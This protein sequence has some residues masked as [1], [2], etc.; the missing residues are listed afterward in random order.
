MASIARMKTQK[1]TQAIV[2]V[3]S[4]CICAAKIS[5]ALQATQKRNL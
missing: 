5:F 4:E 3:A 2:E 1:L